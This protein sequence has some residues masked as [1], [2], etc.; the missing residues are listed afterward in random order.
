[1]KKVK[2][3]LS[4]KWVRVLLIIA[5][6]IAVII[7]LIGRM[8][9]GMMQSLNDRDAR[10]I[11]VVEKMDINTNITSDGI[12]EP[13]EKYNVTA[14]V[15]GEVIE[16]EFEEG[17]EVTKDQVL[18][19][20]DMDTIESQIQDANTAIERANRRSGEASRDYNDAN[21][22]YSDLRITSLVSGQITALSPKVGDMIGAGV[23]IGK[24][25][26]NTVMTLKVPF[27]SAQAVPELIGQIANIRLEETLETLQGNITEIS[28]LEE[29]LNGGRLVKMVT[30][31]VQNPGGL[32]AGYTAVAEVSGIVSA[33]VG[34][35]EPLQERPLI[36]KASGEVIAVNAKVGDVVQAGQ[37]ILALDTENVTKQVNSYKSALDSANDAVVDA[38]RRLED[39]QDTLDNYQIKAPISGRIIT[40]NIKAGDKLNS[41]QVSVMAVIY[42]MSVF[43]FRMSIDELD[44]KKIEV[45]QKVIITADAVPNE[46]LTGV[47]ESISLES[48]NTTGIT[49][50]PVIIRLDDVGE[51]YPG[52]TVNGEIHT[53]T[54]EGV[55]AIPVNALMRGQKVYIKDE[56]VIERV[57][58]IPAGFREI[59]VKVGIMNSDYVEI[60]EG[61]SEG[62]EIYIRPRTTQSIYDNMQ[63]GY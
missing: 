6:I 33:D 37:V 29:V 49:Q 1:M 4:K 11:V 2:K 60:I 31:Q 35:F 24:I 18:Y 17:D 53:E 10:S 5:A 22:L 62:D 39:L 9:S 54:R 13:L 61:L 57:G 40:K 59:D 32:N 19:Q 58:D 27:V 63:G 25:T 43:K 44:I 3:I 14:L 34:Y 38:N 28:Q 42:D 26:D 8:T 55:L 50:Y 51:L 45:G 36:A 48:V 41:Q 52:M 21:G 15:T 30:I 46:E 16:A 7:F 12:I 23:E 47:V 56:T 20:I